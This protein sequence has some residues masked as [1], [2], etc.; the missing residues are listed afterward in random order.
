MCIES[1]LRP[2]GR[3]VLGVGLLPLAYWYCGF[4]CHKRHG[5]LSRECCV[6]SCR[7]LSDV[8]IPRPE[9]PYCPRVCV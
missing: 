8:L 2:G 1:N 3:P 9:E 5:C 6:L 4:E 7:G